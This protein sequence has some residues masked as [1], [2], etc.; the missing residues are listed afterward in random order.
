MDA[1]VWRCV[2]KNFLHHFH[3]L[4]LLHWHNNCCFSQLSS[5][6]EKEE[7]RSFNVYTST[8]RQEGKGQRGWPPRRCWQQETNKHKEKRRRGKRFGGMHEGKRVCVCM[9][10]GERENNGGGN[11][12]S[13]KAPPFYSL[14]RPRCLALS[15]SHIHTHAARQG[16]THTN[17]HT[18]VFMLHC[19][20]LQRSL[21]SLALFL[22]E[23]QTLARSLAA[24]LVWPARSLSREGK[25]G[26][27]LDSPPP[28]SPP[29]SSLP[30]SVLSDVGDFIRQGPDFSSFRSSG[31]L[32]RSVFRCSTRSAATDAGGGFMKV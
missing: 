15:L 13:F 12:D 28:P 22:A 18:H 17:T 6:K 32:L 31:V 29:A 2:M 9:C 10:V 3:P 19:Q 1:G 4:L 23:M 25:W 8:G 16:H 27:Q 11:Q 30:P 14:A 21:F 26:N 20:S 7:G 5:F 24:A